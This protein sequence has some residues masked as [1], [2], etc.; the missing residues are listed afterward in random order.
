LTATGHIKIAD[1]GTAIKDVPP[2][3]IKDMFVGT[4]QYVSPEI[5]NEDGGLS[6]ASDLWAVGC[7]MYQLLC[8]K[9]PF[10][11]DTE[12]LIFVAINGHL[13]GTQPI[14]YPESIRAHPDSIDLIEGLL[15]KEPNERYGAGEE[16]SSNNSYL[17]L[18]NHPFL[19]GGMIEFCNIFS[20]AVPEWEAYV[21]TYLRAS[22]LSADNTLPGEILHDGALDDWL[23]EG[24]ATPIMNDQRP[25]DVVRQEEQ[26]KASVTS[27][28]SKYAKYLSPG[29]RDLFAGL[30]YKRVVRITPPFTSSVAPP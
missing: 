28:S 23:L 18:K 21:N 10:K 20:H 2:E 24:D 14:V 1:F 15:R 5:L 27:A 3:G 12:Y 4:A 30:V 6:K 26:R 29:E 13:D 16:S 25:S 19:G 9:T 22:T 8:G 17:A 11:A 7:M